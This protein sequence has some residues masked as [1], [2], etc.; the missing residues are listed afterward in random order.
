[1]I[2][3]ATEKNIKDL[4]LISNNSI[5]RSFIGYYEQRL[6][7]L[8]IEKYDFSFFR[9]GIKRVKYFIYYSDGNPVWM[10]WIKDNVVEDLYV[11]K[12]F[13]GKWI[14]TELLEYIIKEAKEDWLK[15]LKLESSK[16]WRWFYE[17]IWFCFKGELDK[18]KWKYNYKNALYELLL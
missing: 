9:E 14:W 6:I 10:I 2:K 13:Q 11:L 18:M 4:V 3:K 5:K 12:E 1:M 15:I 8:Y 17:K 16:T 7:D